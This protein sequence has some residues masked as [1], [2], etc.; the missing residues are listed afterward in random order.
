MGDYD[1]PFCPE[2][3]LTLHGDVVALVPRLG[4]VAFDPTNNLIG[5]DRH[6]RVAI[7]RD[8]ADVPPTRGVYSGAHKGERLT[9]N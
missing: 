9:A 1:L 4:C 6:I 8:Y 5:S 2:S 3:G 7:A